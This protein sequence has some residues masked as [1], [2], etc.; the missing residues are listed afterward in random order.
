MARATSRT[1]TRRSPPRRRVSRAS[2][3]VTPPHR[4]TVSSP[5]VTPIRYRPSQDAETPTMFRFL[6]NALGPDDTFTGNSSVVRQID[7]DEVDNNSI[8]INETFVS[9]IMDETNITIVMDYPLDISGNFLDF[10]YQED[11]T[12]IADDV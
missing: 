10:S 1:T 8:M 5:P 6:D 11:P 12:E 3:P 4:I 2:P 7:F 9:T